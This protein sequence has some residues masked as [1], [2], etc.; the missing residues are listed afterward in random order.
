MADQTTIKNS[1]RNSIRNSISGSSGGGD[2]CTGGGSSRINYRVYNY[3]TTKKRSW[4]IG[5][6]KRHSSKLE[7]STVSTKG[8]VGLGSLSQRQLP[9]AREHV[10]SGEVAGAA[11]L[12][13]LEKA[14]LELIG[15]KM[16]GWKM[17]ELRHAN[18]K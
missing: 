1:I 8:Q 3:I 4:H 16:Q 2:D 12:A 14:G 6:P 18:P 5:K 11:E 13:G 7:Q 10:N 17:S 9:I 15:P